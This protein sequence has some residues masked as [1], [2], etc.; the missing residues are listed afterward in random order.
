MKTQFKLGQ[1]VRFKNCKRNSDE[2]EA[3]FIVIQE[4]EANK[5]IV[6]YTLNSNRY[7]I[8]GTTVIPE[9]P[10]EDL[11]IVDLTPSHLIDEHI[12]IKETLFGEVV[13]GKF[14]FLNSDNHNLRFKKRGTTLV[15][16]ALFEFDVEGKHRL[17][18][19][20]LI[21]MDCKNYIH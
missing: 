14:C 15:S 4:E 20:M 21:D 18:G 9:F 11:R 16:D 10:E 8:T 19:P 7:Y 17:M 6:L 2:K 3:Y 1:V 12:A 13:S 5:E